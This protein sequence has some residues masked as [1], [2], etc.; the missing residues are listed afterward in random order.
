MYNYEDTAESLLF[1]LSQPGVENDVVVTRRL[2]K[3]VMIQSTNGI[4]IKVTKSIIITARNFKLRE[5]NVFTSMCQE[6]CPGGRA[7]HIPPGGY[8]EMR[9]MSGRYASYW[10]VFLLNYVSILPTLNYIST[11]IFYFYISPG[12]YAINI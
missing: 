7:W 2:L 9:S 1:D 6:F 4:Y 11:F 8:Y 5:G 3:K 10:N 12:T